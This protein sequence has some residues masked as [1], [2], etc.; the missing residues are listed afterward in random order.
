MKK[1]LLTILFLTLSLLVLGSASAADD[2][3]Q[4]LLS[5]K[6]YKALNQAQELMEKENYQQAK[7]QL[8]SLLSTVEKGSYEQAVVL[9]TLGFLYSS[10]DQYKK[11]TE[12]FQQALDLNALPEDVTHTLR[13]N[14]AQLLIADEQYK[15]GI[16]LMESWLAAEK[17]PDNTVY[18]LLASAYYRVNNF[19]KAA[20]RIQIAIKNDK[21]PQ[22]DWYRLLLSSYLSLKHYKSAISVL[23]LLITRYP[24]KKMYWDQLAALYMQE[25][26]EFTSLA[27]RM[28]A[29]R[30]DLTEPKT[31]VNL[32][33][34]YR[35]LRVPYKA[36]QLLEQGMKQNVIPS[37]F[38]NLN[39]LADS[40]LA[41]RENQRAVDTLK[42][43]LPMD[44]SGDTQL[45]LGQIYISME[46]WGNAIDTLSSAL[47]LLKGK[48]LG[49]TYAML[50]TAYYH[51][52]NFEQAKAQF[53]KAA[54]FEAQKK[55]AAQW[56][57][58]INSLLEK[59]DE[60]V[61]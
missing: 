61:A 4:F 42:V 2:E 17:K 23:E 59:N 19:S 37:N 55:Q 14:L 43:M 50:G 39:K 45:K 53:L 34:M 24:D 47:K 1:P 35:Y 21:A 51:Q 41:A 12:T 54:S 6:T 7:Q 30:L 58:H 46:Q 16:P 40:W 36:G 49:Q 10:L 44:N 31:L 3:K 48:K 20:D 29:K 57:Q 28:L 18:V 26:K 25:N 56:L 5:E 52:D 38:E 13:Y 60:P 11:A 15:K 33:D 32:A 22:E 27:V 9:Q 8:D